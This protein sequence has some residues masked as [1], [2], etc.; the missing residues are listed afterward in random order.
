M[1]E[2][3]DQK[4]EDR[5][6]SQ[7]AQILGPARNGLVTF[8]LRFDPKQKSLYLGVDVAFDLPEHVLDQIPGQVDHLPVRVRRASVWLE[9]SIHG[10]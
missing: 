10:P 1:A 6:Y 4:A 9:G 5:L 2:S 7:L 3:K 8:G